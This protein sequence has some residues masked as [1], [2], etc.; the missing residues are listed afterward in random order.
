MT[1]PDCV[2]AGDDETE[3]LLWRAFRAGFYE[4]GEGLNGEHGTPSDDEL[5]D[6]FAEWRS[7]LLARK[8]PSLSLSEIDE[9]LEV[10]RIYGEDIGP[11]AEFE[12]L[13]TLRALRTEL[14]KEDDGA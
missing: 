14:T 8:V 12:S 11:M 1:R 4:S 2:R 10:L 9:L 5:R 7:C 3:R 13:P 6:R